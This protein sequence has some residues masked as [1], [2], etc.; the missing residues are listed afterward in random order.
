MKTLEEHTAYRHGFHGLPL[1]DLAGRLTRPFD[2]RLVALRDRRATDAEAAGAAAGQLQEVAAAYR[3]QADRLVR[4]RDNLAGLLRARGVGHPT[5]APVL[6]ALAVVGWAVTAV[7]IDSLLSFALH[8]ASV[9]G[10][11]GTGT[12]GLLISAIALAVCR[13]A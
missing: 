2:D 7:G 11:L 4:I 13:V 5:R 3:E 12:S 9:A 1:A 6:A 8:P 10:R